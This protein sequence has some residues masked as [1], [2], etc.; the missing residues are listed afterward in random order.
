MHTAAGLSRP[1]SKRADL[2]KGVS[3]RRHVSPVRLTSFG[4]SSRIPLNSGTRERDRSYGEYSINFREISQIPR[5]NPPFFRANDDRRLILLKIHA[6]VLDL[7]VGTPPLK[8]PPRTFPKKPTEKLGQSR[9]SRE[10]QRNYSSERS[11]RELCNGKNS[12]RPPRV[13]W[14]RRSPIDLSRRIEKKK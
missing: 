9:A 8:D 5:A 11:T 3:S 4:P 14:D 6:P 7:V 10:M 12:C 2:G 1:R 13:S